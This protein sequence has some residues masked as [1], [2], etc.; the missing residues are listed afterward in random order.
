[1]ESPLHDHSWPKFSPREVLPWHRIFSWFLI[2]SLLILAPVDGRAEED[3]GQCC[4][5]LPALGAIPDM[6]LDQDEYDCCCLQEDGST[7][8]ERIQ[9]AYDVQIHILGGYVP[10]YGCGYGAECEE[11]GVDEHG[12]SKVLDCGEDVPDPV[13]N[14]SGEIRGYGLCSTGCY[15]FGC[16]PKP[17]EDSLFP[18]SNI[19][20]CASPE[21]GCIGNAP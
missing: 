9:N 16:K 1:M 10:L 11:V 15:Q 21:D 5:L 18:S 2:A 8:C 6:W 7:D 13:I 12:F 17:V 19:C 4:V 3:P 14:L 20:D